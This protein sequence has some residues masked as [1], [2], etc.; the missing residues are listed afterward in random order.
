MLLA[1]KHSLGDSSW[2]HSVA[3]SLLALERLSLPGVTEQVR[4]ACSLTGAEPVVPTL[5]PFSLSS[6]QLGNS[7]ELSFPTHA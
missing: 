2:A 7:L 1:P 4:L 6:W 3:F 5:L